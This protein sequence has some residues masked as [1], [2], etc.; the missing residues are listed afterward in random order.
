MWWHQYCLC[1]ALRYRKNSCA[2]PN[3]VHLLDPEHISIQSQKL[4]FS[5]HPQTMKMH[6]SYDIYCTYNVFILVSKWSTMYHRSG[7]FS[8]S[9]CCLCCLC[10][11]QK[12]AYWHHFSY[13]FLDSQVVPS[14]ADRVRKVFYLLFTK[15]CLLGTE[16]AP[17]GYECSIMGIRIHNQCPISNV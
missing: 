5:K 4:L 12:H 3:R 7:F 6:A 1:A 8:Y 17:I 15:H 10:K 2:Q 14:K 9:V 16:G 11:P 13:Q